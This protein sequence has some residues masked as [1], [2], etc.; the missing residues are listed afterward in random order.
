MNATFIKK[1]ESNSK[2]LTQ[3]LYKMSH[4]YDCDFIEYGREQMHSYL[5]ASRGY[6]DVD[7]EWEVLLFESNNNGKI[8][9]W[10][11]VYKEHGWHNTKDVIARYLNQIGDQE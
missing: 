7:D 11:E 10:T 8:I 9:S 3:D 1:Y 4:S 6:N 5:L 2:P